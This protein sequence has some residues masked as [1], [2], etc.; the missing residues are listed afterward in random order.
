MNHILFDP[1]YRVDLL[2]LALTRPVSEF[3]IGIITITE[4]WEKL[5][6]AKPSFITEAYLSEKYKTI[7]TDENLLINGSVLPNMEL[8]NEINALKINQ[9]LYAN[10]LLIAIKLDKNS[11]EQFNVTTFKSAEMIQCIVEFKF[12]RNL[13]DVFQLNEFAIIE[14]FK[15]ITKGRISKPISSTNKLIN[16][17]NIFI[18]EGAIVEFAILNAS[19]GPIYIGKDAEVMEGSIVR[20]PLAL[21]EHSALKLGTKIYGATTVGPHS[22]VGGELNNVVIFGFTN[23][24]HDGFLGNAVVGEWC[25]LGADTNN[26]NLKNDYSQVKIWN[27]GQKRFISTGLQFCGLFMGDHSKCGINT[28]FNT[29]TVVGVCCNIFGAGFPRNFLP[30]FTWGGPQGME[31]YKQVKAFKVIEQVMLRRNLQFTDID[32]NILT[33][34]FDETISC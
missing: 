31:V 21:C 22:K 24:A 7:I 18:E 27:Y 5:L 4:K 33:A 1:N 6:N 17:E 26:S 16:K 2:P 34:I 28:M 13:W 10:D 25:N 11:T 19:T 20:G 14:D 32:Q 30:S 12:I 23:K 15:L 9:A 8:I 29:G 3:R